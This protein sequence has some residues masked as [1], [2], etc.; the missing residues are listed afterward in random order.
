MRASGWPL[1]FLLLVSCGGDQEYHVEL[2]KFGNTKESEESGAVSVEA[3]IQLLNDTRNADSLVTVA[4][5]ADPFHPSSKAPAP[6]PARRAAPPVPSS[7]APR[8]EGIVQVGGVAAASIGGRLYRVGDRIDGWVIRRI[9]ES[10]V[11]IGS[12]RNSTVVQVGEPLPREGSL[13]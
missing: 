2:P 8:V 12:A 5:L 6:P 13:R 10:A 1:L 3:I 4:A 9:D 11:Q 7:S